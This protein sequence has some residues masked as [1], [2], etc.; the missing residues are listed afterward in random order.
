MGFERFKLPSW[1]RDPQLDKCALEVMKNGKKIGTIT[2]CSKNKAVVFG[3][4]KNFADVLLRHPSISR[5][6]AA[7]LHGKSGNMYV[8]DLGSSHGT[9]VNKRKL[10]G[11]QREPLED[12]DVVRFG[13]SSREYVVR[14]CLDGGSKSSRGSKRSADSSTDKRKKKKRKKDH[15]DDHERVG[16]SHLLVKHKD[17]RRPTSWRERTIERTKE[18]AEK[19][20]TQ[21]KKEIE[22]SD[23]MEEKFAELAKQYSDCNSHSRGGDLG[24]FAKGKMQ[25]PFE[26]CAFSLKVGDLSGLVNTQS[27]VHLILRTS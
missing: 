25:K 9:Y 10:E 20:V 26:E 4:H 3:R 23:N 19:L 24:K 12:G 15:D 14:L 11:E 6:H 7:I 27:G 16:C 5:Q 21:Y 17:S 8:M 2:R 22:E 13:A 1:A 18:E